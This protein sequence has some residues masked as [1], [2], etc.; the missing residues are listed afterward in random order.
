MRNFCKFLHMH[1]LVA[2]CA[3]IWR[4][5]LL[6]YSNAHTLMNAKDIRLKKV[7]F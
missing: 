6:I 1:I 5:T 2:V 4:L 7:P 3:W